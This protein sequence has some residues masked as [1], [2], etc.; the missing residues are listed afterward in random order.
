MKNCKSI[1]CVLVFTVVAAT[2][3]DAPSLTF[4]FTKASVPGAIATRPGGINNT[5]MSVGDYTDSSRTSTTVI[6]SRARSSPRW[7]TRRPKLA[8]L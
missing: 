4:K 2:A 6:F 1:L 7:M 5:G 3:A 8:L